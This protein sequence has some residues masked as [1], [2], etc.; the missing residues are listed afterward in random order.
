MHS[1]HSVR[2][3]YSQADH[4]SKL[5]P[6]DLCKGNAACIY[7]HSLYEEPV[8]HWKCTAGSWSARRRQTSGRPRAGA[9]PVGEVLQRAVLLSAANNSGVLDSMHKMLR[10]S[11]MSSCYP[12]PI[13]AHPSLLTPQV[14][15]DQSGPAADSDV[16]QGHY[17]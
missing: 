12:S 16:T 17:G 4:Y 15:T 5:L 1:F 14:T 11:T 6:R 7:R 10:P 8:L 3:M 13:P 2:D 9:E